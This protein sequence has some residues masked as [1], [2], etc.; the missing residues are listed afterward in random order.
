MKLYFWGAEIIKMW[1][2]L[3]KCARESRI[4]FI[5]PVDLFQDLIPG[6]WAVVSPG[7]VPVLHSSGARAALDWRGSAHPGS[8]EPYP[9]L[10]FRAWKEV[11]GLCV[12]FSRPKLCFS[13]SFGGRPAAPQGLPQHLG[14]ESRGLCSQDTHSH[15]CSALFVACP[16][17]PFLWH[18]SVLWSSVPPLGGAGSVR[19][20]L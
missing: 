14:R 9:C 6:W 10:T 7:H 11:S 13:F 19:T 4:R 12:W 17:P 1:K 15:P 16:G 2:H 18:S 20:L 3:Q 5:C 8:D